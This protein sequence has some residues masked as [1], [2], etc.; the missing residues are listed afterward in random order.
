MEYTELLNYAQVAISTTADL[1]T[2]YFNLKRFKAKIS[3][4][5]L[6]D[7]IHR[8]STDLELI[9]TEC[10]IR[11][12]VLWQDLNY[13]NYDWSYNSIIDLQKALDQFASSFIEKDDES[14]FFYS[15]L[16]RIWGNKCNEAYKELFRSGES[17]L[18]RTLKKFRKNSY[19]I[20][21]T[22]IYFLPENNPLRMDAMTKLERG[23]KNT[24]ITIKQII[25]EW[26]I[27]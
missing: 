27:E 21:V 23:C 15:Q 11:K 3:A 7:V 2:T 4:K 13:E 6:D 8:G 25:P 16:L 17:E 12:E 18:S 10:F 19:P 9:L 5:G 14:K 20:I 1:T 22:F 26:T 24:R